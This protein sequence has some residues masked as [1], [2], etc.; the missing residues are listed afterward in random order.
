MERLEASAKALAG[1]REV[2]Q[3]V[4][5]RAEVRE[6]DVPVYSPTRIVALRKRAGLSQ[7]AMALM[8]GVS[9]RTV[10]AWESGKNQPSG[11]SVKLLFLIEQD[12]ELVS[13]LILLS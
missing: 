4:R 12:P 8:L 5:M 3:K 10:E 1:S 9:P 2:R 6:I 11:T 13:K 7:R